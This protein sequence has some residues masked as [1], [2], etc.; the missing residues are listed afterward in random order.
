MS[1]G[2]GKVSLSKVKST[3][4]KPFIQKQSKWNT[5]RGISRWAMP[6][7]KLVTVASS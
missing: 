3:Q 2:S 1:A 6:S 4:W 5:D 7:M